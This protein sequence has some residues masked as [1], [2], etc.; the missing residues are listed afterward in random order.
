MPRQVDGLRSLYSIPPLRVARLVFEL[1]P[2][3]PLCM[4]LEARSNVL[5]G[6]CGTILRKALCQSDCTEGPNCPHRTECAY[7]MLFEPD[8]R[9]GANSFRSGEAPRAYLFRPSRYDSDRSISAEHPLRFELRLFGHGVE[10][11][12]VFVFAFQQVARTGLGGRPASLISVRSLDWDD[13]TAS[14]LVVG[15][16]QT[17]YRP[18]VLDFTSLAL[19]HAVDSAAMTIRFL[20]P[21][22][23]KVGKGGER[24][25]SFGGLIQRL[26]DR[27]SALC[28]LH[29]ERE[30][31]ADFAGI[32]RLAELVENPEADGKWTRVYRHSS[33]TR[34]HMPLEGFIGSLTY[35][36]VPE[37][38]LPL[39]RIGEELH[40]GQHTVWG[41]GRFQCVPVKK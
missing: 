40:V 34:K 37:D 10:A 38:L 35:R 39:L 41:Y 31:Q 18:K 33:R 12:Q 7:A 26:R 16:V 11:A 14:E 20:T 1:R 28:R 25:P 2:N 6:A 13:K 19:Q 27:V 9:A 24:V 21:V 15:G 30:W 36:H 8:W 3:A 4:P 23:L 5:R 29:E 22:Y 32:G 17:R